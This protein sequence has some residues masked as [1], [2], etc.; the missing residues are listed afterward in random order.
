[1]PEYV[2]ALH[3]FVPE[4]EDEISFSA[5]D[6]IEVIEKDELYGDGW[7]QGRNL[8]GKIG[9]FP[10]TYT[11]SDPAVVQNPAAPQTNGHNSRGAVT[12]A[13]LHTLNEEAEDTAVTPDNEK[14]DEGHGVMRA[15]MTDVQEAIEQLGRND[16]DGNGSFSFASTHTDTDRDTDTEAGGENG[17]AWH[18][19][20]RSNLAEKARKQ[21]ELLRQ[22]QE[23]YDAELKRHAPLLIEQISEPPLQFEMSDESE[24]EEEE[25]EHGPTT[26][27]LFP[28]RNHDHI[29]EEEEDDVD[30][31]RQRA[32]EQPIT[33]K[34][35][36]YSPK[37][38]PSSNLSKPEESQELEVQPPETARQIS[39]PTP[40]HFPTETSG[41]PQTPVIATDK[42]HLDGNADTTQR[43]VGESPSPPVPPIVEPETKS[44][45]AQTALPS[46]PASQKGGSAA[47]NQAARW[48]TVPSSEW[49]VD[50]VVEWAKSKGFDSSVTD[51]FIEHE[52]SGDVLLELDQN[53]LK[54][55]L[56]IHAFGKRARIMKEITELKRPS[57]SMSSVQSAPSHMHTHQRT[58]SQSVSIPGSV[59]H[60]L[61]S[62]MPMTA[63]LSPE[64]P[65]HTGDL[66]GTP[67]FGNMRRDSDP[68]SSMRVS[69]TDHDQEPDST[70]ANNSTIDGT[71]LGLGIGVAVGSAEHLE[72]QKVKN[73]PAY[74]NL[75]PSEH[76][77]NGKSKAPTLS[78]RSAQESKEERAALSDT[79]SAHA[80]ESRSRR[81]RLFGRSTG[82]A[83]SDQK[84]NGSRNS[85][86]QQRDLGPTTP[87]SFSTSTPGS[88]STKRGST[89]DGS[90]KF[91]QRRKRSVDASKTSDR[92]SLFGGSLSLSRSRKPPPRMTSYAH[93]D[94]LTEKHSRS[95]SRLY[96]GSGSRKASAKSQ[97]TVES[98]SL[99]KTD[100]KEGIDPRVLRKRT[101]SNLTDLPAVPGISQPLKAGQS[102]LEQIG[103][104]DHNGWL[105]KKGEHYNTWKLRY[106]VLKGPH[107]YY[108]RSN[109]KA[110]TRIKGYINI[111]GYKV[112]VD[113]NI[114]P[115]KYGFRLIHETERTHYFSADESITIREWMKALMKATI[116]RD[117]SKPVISSCNIPTIPLSVA[118]T[119]N[120]SPRPPSPT[121]R[122]ATQKALRR[123]NPNQLSSR[124][125]RILMGLPSAENGVN[126]NEKHTVSDK[127]PR[128]GDDL[129]SALEPLP[130]SPHEQASTP[131]TAT[132]IVATPPPARPS[133]ETRR[134]SVPPI[135]SPNQPSQAN[136]PADLIRWANSY[137]PPSL[138]VQENSGQI[139][140][141]LAL[142]RLA[143]G[144]KG[145]P[146]E[147][148]VPDSAFPSGPDD[149]RLDGL[150]KLFD[151]FLDNEVRMGN[152]SINDVRQGR[153]DKVIQLLRSLRAWEEKRRALARSIGRS[154]AQVGPFMAL[155][156]S[157][158][159]MATAHVW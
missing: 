13:S 21:Q 68:G 60:S 25:F 66:A 56:E 90:V 30:S 147:P 155:E 57:S 52:I 38:T 143:E 131:R 85:K 12:P 80:I 3:D 29:S 142:F 36:A 152:V 105:R 40:T 87:V 58:A 18:K 23:A 109:S 51:K 1:M 72:P 148:P 24:D 149:D 104:P 81:R 48:T 43:I 63:M 137:L 28:R 84:E 17:E 2:Y 31:V 74:L 153:M 97:S 35:A 139:Y 69:E 135:D 49:S 79:E 134:T 140:S 82:S 55:E 158:T 117:Y 6:R 112:I 103:T 113:E 159:S 78:P 89:E 146:S 26:N 136:P 121:Q 138:Q 115:G 71:G 106:F 93:D 41:R 83:N 100:E 64:S 44:L 73:R 50:D 102:V 11:T 7:W 86:E 5:G 95:L 129:F 120:P 62:P 53:V 151:F 101:T 39:F 33:P 22:E 54:T 154:G 10:Q 91:P 76:S 132:N 110:E 127:P 47:M 46:P 111:I 59:H 77:L 67:A 130:E 141:G 116:G 88:P 37:Q 157:S 123:E 32:I 16:R 150:F 114:N 125:A 124:D 34:A 94:L 42:P 108:L 19:G 96:L 45:S 15:T 133:R 9:L 128:I 156:P 119:M 122:A 126:G 144:I 98:S 27:T 20:A 8:F 92:L 75:S 61:R 70:T 107:L 99:R 118:Q 65:P 145:K 4:N 14:K